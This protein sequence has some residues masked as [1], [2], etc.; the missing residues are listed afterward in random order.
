VVAIS[1]GVILRDEHYHLLPLRLL[2]KKL[3]N[4]A[5][6]EVIVRM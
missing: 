5:E 1:T 2:G 6:G 3:Q 4:T